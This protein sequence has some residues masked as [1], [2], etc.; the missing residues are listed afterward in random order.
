MIAQHDSVVFFF[1]VRMLR[2]G[3]LSDEQTPTQTEEEH[4]AAGWKDD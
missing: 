3:E 4:R 1:F 2:P